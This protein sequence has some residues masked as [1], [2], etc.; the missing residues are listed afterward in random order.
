MGVETQDN[1]GWDDFS[2]KVMSSLGFKAGVFNPCVYWCKE[3]DSTCWR[4]GD[5]FVLLATRE[6]H[7]KFLEE[8]NK[9]MM[10]KPMGILGP[11]PELG[12]IAEVRCLNRLI[13]Y[14][15]PAYQSHDA[16]YV[17]WEADPR[18]LDLNGQSWSEG[19]EQRLRSAVC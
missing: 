10:L 3:S 7:K 11:C 4:H 12:D 9:Q 6:V 13:R 19:R 18:H 17:E 8:A 14:V 5:D 16:G 15:Q 2:E 1:A